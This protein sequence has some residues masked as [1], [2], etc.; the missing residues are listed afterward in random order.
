MR[1]TDIDAYLSGNIHFGWLRQFVL[2]SG[3]IILGYASVAYDTEFSRH[4]DS[5]HLNTNILRC[6]FPLMFERGRRKTIGFSVAALFVNIL[7]F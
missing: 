4:Y 7:L 2:A 5:V 1:T 6:N 3:L